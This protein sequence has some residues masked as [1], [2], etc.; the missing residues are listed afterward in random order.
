MPRRKHPRHRPIGED[1]RIA[2]N[3][4][5]K[6]LLDTPDQKELEFPSS[7][8]AEERAY[9]HELAR[10]LGLKSKSRGKGMNRF[11]TVYKREGSTIVQA[12]AVIKLQNASKQSIYNLS[13]TFPLN[14]KEYQ[15]LLPPI[16]RERPLSTDVNTNT[17]AMGRLNSSIP[18]VPQL[19]T[20]FDVLH[21]RKSL[22]IFNSREEIL[23]AL[24][25]YQV[26]IIA[27]ETGCGK[28]T[29]VPQYILEH[30]Q[31]KHQACRIIC[32]QPR[33][34]SAVSV[35]ERV[36]F[37][38][39]EK[40]GQTFGYQIRLE[41]R[42]APKTL[43][44][45]CTNGVLLRT[46]MG[47]DSALSTLTH[48]IV[49]EVHERDR[50]CD[51]LM[52]ALKDA[53]VKYR[54]LKLILMSATMDTS[55]FVKYF[56]KCTV[57]NVPGRSYDV[58]VYFLEDILKMTNYMTKEMLAMKK[59][60]FKLKDQRKVLESWTQYKPQHSSRNATK[61]KCLLPAPILAQQSD[62]IPERVKLEPWLME[63]MDKSVSDAWLHGGE[64]NFAQLLHFI[65]SENVSVDYQHSKTSVTPLMVAAGRGCINTTEQLLNLGA[66]L[67]LRAGNE[68]TALDW[69]KKM[70]QTECAEL[71][72]AYMKTYDCVVSND[73]LVRVAETSLA[74]EDKIL[75]DIY[76]HTF[77]DD[78]ID[79]NLL[80]ELIFHVHL[81]MQPGS[82]LIFLPGYDDI[83]IMREKINAEEKKMSQNSRYNLY[84]LHSNM[85]T[86]D[87]KKV[88][89]SSPHGTRKII[90]STNIAETSITIDD[91]VYVID[92]GKV[93]EKSFDAI[94]GVCTL[95]SNW[96]SQ[97]CA[98]QRKGR[99]GR[100]KRGICYRMFSSVRHNSMQPYQTPEIL[101]LPLQELCLYT[102]YLTPG[103]TP[104]AEFLDR[105][106]EPPSNIVTRNAV[107][108]LKTIDALDPWEDLTEM[109]SHLLDLPVEP[110]LGKM[111]LY[112]VVLKC[113]DPILTIVCSL[114]YKDPFILPSQP[115]QKR[116]LTAARKKFATGTYSD[117]MVVLRAFQGWQNARASG[118][119]RAFCEKNFISAPV[120]EMVVGMRTQLLGQLRASGFVRARSPSDIRDLNSNSENWAVVKA[121]LTAGLYPNLIRVDRDHLQLRTQ[122]EVKVFFHP[123]S[124]LRDFP[125]S[126]RMTS[127]Q[128]HAANVQ[129]LPCDWLLYEEMSRTGRFCHVKFVTLVNPLTVALFSGPA[130]LPMDVLHEAEAVWE[131][132]S[133][134]EV[135]ESHEGTI[136]KLDDWVVFKLDPETADLFLQLR[137]KWN[138]LFLRRM[139]APNKAMSALD[140]KVI[141]TLVTVLT[142][143][144]QACGLQQPTGIGQRPRPLIVDYYPANVRR[145]DYPE[146]YF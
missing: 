121:A 93:K 142:N 136:F 135:D 107:Q 47:G 49:D 103:N 28:T 8:T 25:N 69:A 88:F 112:A 67:N 114:A 74:E 82:I 110:R 42:V 134:S 54:S 133:D 128:T 12:D 45:Y 140:E 71:I 11:L 58:D 118:K 1:T 59:E 100:C 53:L 16:E 101:R 138:A 56:N 63:E 73:E 94:S 40:I 116:A 3:L 26:V 87:Q 115:S 72:E 117:H 62:P 119:E 95:T 30:C 27:G 46:L 130:R 102:K 129:A 120:M 18:Q 124:T 96:I 68:W 43:L 57:I 91:V 34:L 109:G 139:K 99:A 75:L 84:V 85:Q 64:D 65:L 76:H 41:S 19:K 66:N 24:N 144:E 2:V 141:N 106:L 7:Y 48:I 37:E 51:F 78:N 52:I 105:A 80:L 39:D 15:D 29:Q 108:L 92:S 126:P 104:I 89:K 137:Q 9:I 44:T 5:L 111:L 70:N 81:K 122:K 131:S 83:V 31:Q 38:R 36:A 145:D 14:Q 60:F 98:K 127:A 86:C 113:L 23:A 4:T 123:S 20:N 17:K 10:G 146:R 79:Y 132:D 50:F 32:T 6:K 21:F 22:P 125:K 55:I 61:E 35:A 90:L 77:N 97:A 33:R 13:H 143:E